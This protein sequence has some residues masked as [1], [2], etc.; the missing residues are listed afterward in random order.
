[1]SD[2]QIITML[3]EMGFGTNFRIDGNFQ[4]LIA[5]VRKHLSIFKKEVE[6]AIYETGCFNTE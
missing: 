3:R 2:E 5:I 4:P 6:Y 1:M